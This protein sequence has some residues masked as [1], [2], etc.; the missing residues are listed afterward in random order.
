MLTL[1]KITDKIKKKLGKYGKNNKR[2]GLLLR[3]SRQNQISDCIRNTIG[4]WFFYL[5]YDY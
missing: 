1:Y 4:V 2:V 5:N 3:N